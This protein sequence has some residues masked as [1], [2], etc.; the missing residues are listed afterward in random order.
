MKL[1]FRVRTLSLVL[2]ILICSLS[3]SA[4]SQTDFSTAPR[5]KPDG[6][7]WRIGYLQGG[8]YRNYPG[9]LLATVQQLAEL[10]WIERP[11]FPQAQDADAA[12]NL[13]AW[14]A[15]NARSQYIEFV[16]D[17]FWSDD[18]NADRRK[19]NKEL[20]LKKLNGGEL[21]L[22]IAMGTWAG[23][24]LSND[25][26]FIP[27]VVCSTSD[28][29]AAKIV[30]SVE[31]SGHDHMHARVD[32]NRYERQI[33]LFHDII[34][35]KKLG[36]P[37]EDS[38]AGR[39]YCSIDK[40]EKVAK[41]LNFE[42]VR[43]NTKASTPNDQEAEESVIRCAEELAPKVD[44]FYITL[45][46]GVNMKSLPKILAPLNEKKVPTFS[47]AGS[48]EVA[49]GAL[50]SIAQA[51]F[52]YEGRFYAETIAR[53]FNGAKPR[54]VTQLFEDPPKIAINLATA[55]TINWD[56]PMD[57]L[58]AADEIYEGLEHCGSGN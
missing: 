42:I 10:G 34:G 18:W 9:V 50:L 43:C 57:A 49:C 8:P 20:L 36:I 37:Y 35:F 40:I 32:P 23:Q 6:K 13:W 39:T 22:M 1:P 19:T 48:H 41:E 21:D 30:K 15:A 3:A 54:Q 25:S 14:L 58:A 52:K 12:R 5:A 47:Q 28:P 29:V 31:D 16:A 11:T 44:A 26:H 24:D 2:F 7:K 38:D 46:K 4:Y 17:A 27:T 53:I 51:G 56:A 55:K 45:Q 33:R